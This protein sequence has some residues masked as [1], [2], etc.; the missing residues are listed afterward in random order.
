MIQS[1]NVDN[2]NDFK[3]EY[4]KKEIEQFFKKVA[5]AD[6]MIKKLTLWMLPSVRKACPEPEKII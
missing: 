3:I 1:L 5:N 2:E 4:K 6:N